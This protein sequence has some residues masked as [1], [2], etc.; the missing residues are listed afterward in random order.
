[1]RESPRYGTDIRINHHDYFS[2]PCDDTLKLK[3]LPVTADSELVE[4]VS[5]TDLAA[6]LAVELDTVIGMFPQ[7]A[8]VDGSHTSECLQCGGR[9][10]TDDRPA[11]CPEWGGRLRNI[12]VARE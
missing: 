5:V 10:T 6:E 1:V 4:I 3:R 9:A 7:T 8:S 12:S 2:L 11:K